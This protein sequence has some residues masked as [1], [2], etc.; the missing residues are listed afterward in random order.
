MRALIAVAAAAF[1][2]LAGCASSPLGPKPIAQKA[3]IDAALQRLVDDK[4]VAGD[5]MLVFEHGR[6]TYY[7]AAGFADREAGRPMTRDTLAQI[8]SMTKPV[9]GVAIMTLYEKGLFQLDEPVAKYVPELADLKVYAGQDA[10]GKPILVTPPRQPTIRDVM[11]HTAGFA[12]GGDDAGV[13]PLYAAA[14]VNNPDNSLAELARRLG[15][16]PLAYAPGAQWRYSTAVDIQA[17]MVERLS[18][19]SFEAYVQKTIFD[20][21]KMRDTGWYVAE[22]RRG[23]MAVPY[24]RTSAGE[25]ERM[26][27]ADAWRYPYKKWTLRSGSFGLIS[28]LDD[29]MRFAQMLVHGGASGGVRILKPETVRLMATSTLSPSIKERL[30]LPSKGQVGFGIDFAVRVA[31]PATDGENWGEVGE[32]FWD[33]AWSTLFWVDPKNDLTAVFFTQI[34]PFSNFSHKAI[35]DAVYGKEGRGDWKG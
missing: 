6:E 7:G 24:K 12:N 32:F 31:P 4:R 8:W 16:V 23:R 34:Q 28:T 25:L 9:T 11:R 35:R 21:L 17:L 18:G 1:L 30:W 20:P 33:G 26:P 5:S 13:G 3:T 15:T 14:D 22:E 29:Y 19:M 2:T 27:D 10:A